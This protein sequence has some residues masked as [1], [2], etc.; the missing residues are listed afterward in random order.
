M[1]RVF[2]IVMI[3]VLTITPC[4]VV[5]AEVTD[6][7]F[8]K[9]QDQVKD[10][11]SQLE[12]MQKQM[13][14]LEKQLKDIREK[15]EEIKEAGEEKEKEN[16]QNPITTSSSSGD[17]EKPRDA[18]KEASSP[19]STD[20]EEGKNNGAYLKDISL[21]L[22]CSI[23]ADPDGK[24]KSAKWTSSKPDIVSAEGS[25]L[26]ALES[27]SSTITVDDGKEKQVF[28]VTV[29]TP[30]LDKTEVTKI[31]GNS[32]ELDV[33][34]TTGKVEWMSDNEAVATVDEKGVV[35]T[36]LNG[37]GQETDIWALVD[38]T[39]LGC[40]V[41]VE[42][43]PQLMSTYQ[44]IYSPVSPEYWDKEGNIHRWT[45]NTDEY[46]RFE[47]GCIPSEEDF[48][49]IRNLWVPITQPDKGI[50]RFSELYDYELHQT[51]NY[52]LEK[53]KDM[54]EADYSD[55]LTF[56]IYRTYIYDSGY[57]DIGGNTYTDIYLVGSSQD[58]TVKTWEIQVPE[59]YDKDLKGDADLQLED[60]LA[61]SDTYVEYIPEDGYGIIRVCYQPDLV[62][63]SKKEGTD[64]NIY[65]SC[66]PNLISV[67]IDG[68]EYSIVVYPMI[69][70][71]CV[72]QMVDIDDGDHWYIDEARIDEI[73]ELDQSPLE[74]DTQ[75]IIRIIGTS[76]Q[77]LWFKTPEARR[78]SRLEERK[79][80]ANCIRT[81]K[82]SSIPGIVPVSTNGSSG[83]SANIQSVVQESSHFFG[84]GWGYTLDE[85]GDKLVT[86][87]EDKVIDYLTGGLWKAVFGL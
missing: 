39:E 18:K 73:K 43:V 45:T 47:S 26:T 16:F 74:Y 15:D 81:S 25:N 21:A 13:E 24:Y 66:I 8:K 64:I 29:T 83:N 32:F 62:T 56:P 19:A 85:F 69:D 2:A 3:L 23:D 50:Y 55:G 87:A 37:V 6:E 68:F 31:M 35:T 34:G 82:M 57:K 53:T 4:S 1:K 27:G 41:I 52:S 51:L 78:F 44:I 46:I 72:G 11:Q 49:K 80:Y 10:L 71:E 75:S 76:T 12:V 38:G 77:C 86:A 7:E 5:S 9:V 17:Q 70:E 65:S 60:F 59:D 84:T 48:E 42:P 63:Y 14:A 36:Q 61:D 22:E 30:T 79:K 28:K 20:T 54:G 58:A 67:E 33:F 40:H